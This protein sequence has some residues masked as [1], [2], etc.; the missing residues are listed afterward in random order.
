MQRFL[1]LSILNAFSLFYIPSIQPNFKIF[2]ALA[3]DRVWH[4]QKFRNPNSKQLPT[5]PFRSCAN[6][7]V[8]GLIYDSTPPKVVV[9]RNTIYMGMC[10]SQMLLVVASLQGSMRSFRQI[11]HRPFHSYIIYNADQVNIAVHWKSE[12]SDFVQN[13]CFHAL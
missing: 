2:A 9:L 8:R 1:H 13:V 5:Q 7:S 11:D 12:G 10:S 3:Y 6:D 4:C